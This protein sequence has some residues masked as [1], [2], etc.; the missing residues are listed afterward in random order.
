MLKIENVTLRFGGLVA[1]NDVSMELG[2]GMIWGLIGP[3]GAGKT[4]L[5]NIISGV[6]RPD[7]GNITLEAT[8]IDGLQ[9]FQINRLGISRTYQNINLFHSMSVLD[10]VLTGMQSRLRY[11][12][13]GAIFRTPSQRREEREARDRA[14]ELLQFVNLDGR[15]GEMADSL[16]Y[17]EQRRL[18]IVRALAGKPRLLLLDEPAAGMNT[19]EKAD[20]AELIKKIRDFGYTILL[21]E[22]DMKLVMSITDHIFALNYGKLI[23]KGMPQEIQS[24]P[25]VIAAYLGGS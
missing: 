23:A 19:H 11:D 16:P 7:S 15:A 12:L 10:N 9:P 14:M 1:V 8:R 13:A 5:F 6:Y 17:G 22:H 4:T 2:T 3:N 20:L 21:I 25:D 18:E 24:N